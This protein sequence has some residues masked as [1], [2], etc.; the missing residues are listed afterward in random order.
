MGGGG[1]ASV[2]RERAFLNPGIFAPVF[3]DDTRSDVS[4]AAIVVF[5]LI[6]ANTWLVSDPTFVT[7]N[8]KVTIT[9]SMP[10]AYGNDAVTSTMAACVHVGYVDESEPHK[11]VWKAWV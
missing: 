3:R 8:A 6:A 4:K 1:T 2:P 5:L 9:V 10:V 11:A 7:L